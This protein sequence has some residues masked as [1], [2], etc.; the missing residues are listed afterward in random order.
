MNAAAIVNRRD[1]DFLLREWLNVNALLAR[2]RFASHSADSIDAILTLA[3]DLSERE[4]AP[5]L[6]ISDLNEPSIDEAGGVIVLPAVARAVR[7]LGE[8]GFFA[9]VFDEGSGG[10][11]LPHVV[12][13]AIL[14]ILMSA[15]I[16]TPSFLLLTVGNAR[17]IATF[18]SAAQIAAFAEPQIAG[19]AMGTMCLSESQAGS[20]LGDIRTRAQPDGEDRLGRRYRITGN[21]MWI[22]GGDHDVTANIVH[23]VLAKVADP[24]G[25]TVEGTKGIS[26]FIVPKLLPDGDRNDVTPIALNHKM[27]YRGLPNC[28]LNF[29]EGRHAPAGRAGAVGWLV[30]ELGQGLPQMF[31]MMNE[32]RI[33]VGMGAA[34]SAYRGYLLALDYARGRLQGRP[35][36]VKGGTPV[37]IIEHADVKRMLLAQKAYAEGAL[38][39]VLYS[40]RLLDEHNS[41]ETPLERRSAAELLALLTP[42]TKT[43]PAEWGQQ[44]L[45]LAIQ[46]HGGAGY[47]R[48]FDVEQL[49]RDNRLN[50]IHEGTTG[51]QAIDL[52]GRKLRRDGGQAFRQLWARVRATCSAA[53]M[54]LALTRDRDAVNAAWILLNEAVAVLLAETD[55]ARALS[56]A[57]PFLNAI[58]HAVVGWL[59]LDQALDC[60]RALED[61]ISDPER[62]FRA[63]KLRAC[64]YFTE[65][66]LPKI[67]LWLDLA[68]SMTDVAAAMPVDQF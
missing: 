27:G 2:P 9:S 8:A 47:T 42:I 46:I 34:M 64:R 16:A 38:A 49:Y 19:K 62:S 20:S 60:D 36:G 52:V 18:G 30:G 10:L 59:W 33:S 66:E 54:R 12:H 40:A 28:A 31:Q 39:L 48:D 6:R 23:L 24:L 43:W 63:G 67:K 68:T 13:I 55:E 21:K 58:G 3:Q 61:S 50:T 5:L 37:A 22:S 26:L 32:A 45:D 41:A 7:L 17:L 51:I 29:G 56:N 35:V 11:Q 14:G 15:T 44:S 57:T 4:L 53:S 1:I 25:R 65:A